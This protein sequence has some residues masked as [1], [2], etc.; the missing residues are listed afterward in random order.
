M[1]DSQEEIKRKRP[2]KAKEERVNVDID[3]QV[4][5]ESKIVRTDEQSEDELIEVQ[6]P[7]R[8]PK[9]HRVF[10]RG[11][12][13]YLTEAAINVASKDKSLRLEIPQDSKFKAPHFKKC[14]DC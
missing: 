9:T 11:K 12:E 2:R 4:L 13:R 5:S 6:E 7:E 1:E 8:N 14:K 10:I 3:K